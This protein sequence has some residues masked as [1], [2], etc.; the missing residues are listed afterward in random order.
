MVGSTGF[1]WPTPV[2]FTSRIG[3]V[4]LASLVGA[5]LAAAGAVYQAVLGN[6]LA[7]PYLLGASSGA[8]PGTFLWALPLAGAAPII[9]TH[10]GPAGLR[11]GRCGGGSWRRCSILAQRRDPPKISSMLASVATMPL[12][13]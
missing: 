11:V 2:Q 5:S 4:L 7:D 10:P 9:G 3:P 1:G 6:P 13:L 12:S 8:T